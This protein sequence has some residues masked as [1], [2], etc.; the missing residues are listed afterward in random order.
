MTSV[1]G[2][3]KIAGK[4]DVRIPAGM[5]TTV[6]AT[7]YRGLQPGEDSVVLIEPLK[8]FVMSWTGN[9]EHPLI[10]QSWTSQSTS[11]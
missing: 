9:H 4:S 7:G 2:F 5:I 1:R 8:R 11:C 6:D 10:S 3:A